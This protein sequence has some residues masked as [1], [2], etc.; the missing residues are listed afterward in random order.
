MLPTRAPGL[1]VVGRSP[2]D[3]SFPTELRA[4]EPLRKTIDTEIRAGWAKA[5]VTPAKP[6]TD[7]EFLRRVSLD[8]VGVDPDV[9]GDGRVPRQQGP[10]QAG[11]ADRP[12]ARRPAVRPAPGRRL[13]HGPVR[14]Q[15]A[16]L[17]HRPA[18]GLPG[19][20]AVAVR[21][22]HPL[23]L[24]GPR[25]AQGRGEQR[26]ER[27]AVLRP[28]PQRPR[29]R[30][31]GGHARPSSAC[32]SSAPAATTTLSRSGRS[33]SSTA[34]PRSSPGSKS[35]TV[36]KKGNLTVYAIGEKNTGDVRFTGSAKDAQARARR[37]S[38]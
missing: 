31:R 5:K 8:L 11:E 16:G 18:R 26:R 27:G 10:G 36:G 23:R 19:L 12:A 22:E 6:A 4:D 25:T 28:V 34:W 33:A 7:S 30:D 13:G 2:A 35:C 20:A 3:C 29:G 14:P 9:R 24:L 38:R 15:P 37:A 1:S 17:R 21:E 32:N